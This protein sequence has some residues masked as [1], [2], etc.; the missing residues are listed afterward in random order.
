MLAGCLPCWRLQEQPIALAFLA[1]KD[2]HIQ[3]AGRRQ[4]L[5]VVGLRSLF[6]CQ[7][8]AKGL[9]PETVFIPLP[10]ACLHHLKASSKGGS[11]FKLHLFNVP[12][13]EG[14]CDYVAS[15]QLIQGNLPIIL[16]SCAKFLLPNKVTYSQVPG[17]SMQMSSGGHY[18]LYDTG[19]LIT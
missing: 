5:E 6:S 17:I 18:S 10:K 13:F 8:S 1:S 12:S 16:I 4:F 3:V 2:L 7:L 11:S 15:P 9:L 14:L 19:N